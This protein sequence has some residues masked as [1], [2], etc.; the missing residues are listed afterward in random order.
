MKKQTLS[1]KHLTSFSFA[2][3]LGISNSFAQ[4]SEVEEAGEEFTDTLFQLAPL[5]FAGIF[6]FSVFFNLGKVM[7]DNK[8]YKGFFTAVGM[9]VLAISVVLGIVAYL[10]SISL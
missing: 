5:V 1:A 10:T 8:D 2:L 7:G 6:L 3:L 9:Y 4:W